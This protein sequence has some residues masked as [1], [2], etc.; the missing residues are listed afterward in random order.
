MEVCYSF[1]QLS[2]LKYCRKRFDLRCDRVPGLAS[3]YL[4]CL[5]LALLVFSTKVHQFWL[6]IKFDFLLSL[7][8]LLPHL[9][10]HP[11]QVAL[12][13]LH[14]TPPLVINCFDM[15]DNCASKYQ[16]F[17]VWYVVTKRPVE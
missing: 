3:H 15:R 1:D 2:V 11:S 9:D 17:Y 10:N 16:D 8:F 7:L 5:G 12:L 6:K 14:G 4:L 13:N